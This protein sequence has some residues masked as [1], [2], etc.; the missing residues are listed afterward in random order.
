MNGT[1]LLRRSVSM[2]LASSLLFV[3]ACGV[4]MNGLFAGDADIDGATPRDAGRDADAM[5]D[6]LSDIRL[7]TAADEVGDASV[8]DRG[9]ND[10][11]TE[12]RGSADTPRDLTIDPTIDP[13]FDREPPRE[14]SVDHD[15]GADGDAMGDAGPDDGSTDPLIEPVQDAT[16]EDTTTDPTFDAPID[17]GADAPADNAGDSADTGSPGTCGGGCS[18]FPNISPNVMRTV[19]Q[20]SPPVMTGGTVVDGTY[21]V[22]GIVQYNGDTTP[23]SLSETSVIAGN[24]DAWVASTNGQLPVRFTTTFT[25]TGNQM[26]FAFCCPTSGSLTILYTTDGTTLS[27]IDAGNPNRVIT[28]TRQ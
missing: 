9:V 25:T 18:T 3:A 23:Y 14:A 22:S 11:R 2:V 20:G 13:S 8:T 26:V 19:D 4:E 21:V 28:Y 12:D 5:V 15:V 1:L 17:I 24:I 6:R 27:H 7:D 16:A 10:V